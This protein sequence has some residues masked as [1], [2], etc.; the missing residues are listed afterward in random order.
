MLT[1]GNKWLSKK[2]ELMAERLYQFFYI[3]YIFTSS[4]EFC[5]IKLKR[6]EKNRLEKRREEKN[7]IQRKC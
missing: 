5:I 1:K 6:E 4:F 2:M 7:R 3:S